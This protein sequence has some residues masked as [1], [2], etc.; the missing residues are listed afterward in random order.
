MANQYKNKI[1]RAD[2]GEVLMDLTADT[3]EAQYLTRGKTAHAAS[4]APIVGTN[5]YDIDSSEFTARASEIL[6]GKTAGVG[7]Q[8]ITGEMPN[9]GAVAGVISDKTVPYTVPAGFHDG[10]GTVGIDSTEAAKLIADNIKAGV[11]VLGVTGTYAGESYNSQ[12]KSVT[13]TFTAQTVLP[14]AGYDGLSQ[15]NVAAIPY[16]ETDNAAGGVTVTIGAAANG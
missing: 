8:E 2:N 9:R 3:V 4:G 5:D 16:T 12:T 7:G 11:N 1:V 13:P 6:S 10:S 14:D 15:V